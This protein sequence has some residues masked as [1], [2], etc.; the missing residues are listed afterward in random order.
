MPDLGDATPDVDEVQRVAA[1]LGMTLTRDEAFLYR[2]QLV[3]QLKAAE[4]FMSASLDEGGPPRSVAQRSA[5]HR[6]SSEEDPYNA[7][8]WK[9]HINVR[10][11]GPLAGKTVSFKDHIAV[12]GIP[13]SLGAHLLEDFI[14]DCDA[15]I[16]TRVLE[17]GGTIT[18]KNSMNGPTSLWGFGLPGDF[19]RPLNPHNPSHLTGGSSSGSA[20]AVAAGE[21]D[22]SF[23]GDQ[24]G[25]IRIPAAYCGVYGL[26]P[27]FGLVS[28]FGIGF[29][30]DPSV[31][32]VGPMALH[33]EDV[34]AAL[35]SVAGHDP[36]DPRQDRSILDT[37]A[38]R[39]T[40]SRGVKDVRIGILDEGL[41]DT[42]PE[43]R[44]AVMAAV[45]VLAAAGAKVTTVSIPEHR[46]SFSHLRWLVTEGNRAIFDVGFLGAFAKTYY[47]ATLIAAAHRLY[48]QHTDLVNPRTKFQFIV[49]EFTRRRFGGMIY[50]KAQN[51]RESVKRAYDRALARVDVLV[52]PTCD[53]VAPKYVEPESLLVAALNPVTVAN[54]TRPFNYTG[55]PALSVPCGK[56]GRL[57]MGMQLVGRYYEDSLLLRTAY[58]FQH[59]VNWE[60]LISIERRISD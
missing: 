16:V 6:P 35:D 12:A 19:A 26:K 15:T 49:A 60:H 17:S 53:T 52:T 29:G 4:D 55:H 59:S 10:A 24:G 34:A 54:N 40:L 30:S 22:L 20:A 48:R 36:L 33:V 9:C 44:D 46:A 47:P 18:G 31:D 11:D 8:M 43:V 42:A 23:G 2:E 1:S 41:L 27:T 56:S 5:G 21:V 39:G 57:P 13:M 7:W 25:S 45:D 28:H 58:A 51:V 37:Y 3:F 50:A 38:S 32:H 14:P